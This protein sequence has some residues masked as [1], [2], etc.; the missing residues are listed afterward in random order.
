MPKSIKKEKITYDY[1]YKKKISVWQQKMGY[2][3]SV[4]AP[5]L[6]DFLPDWPEK[7]ALEIGT[8]CGIISLLVLFK[9]KFLSVSGIEIQNS[10]YHLALINAKNNSLS[11]K[12]F[13]LLGDFNLLYK[14]FSG[15]EVIFSNP[16]Y[17]KLAQG[18]I[19][20][21]KQIKIARAEV[22]LNLKDLLE[23]SRNILGL[24]GNLFL[25]LP[26]SRLEELELLSQNIGFNITCIRHIHSFSCGK[27]ERFLVQLSKYKEP[28]KK[29]HPLIIFKE[30][31]IYT[32]EMEKILSG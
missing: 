13:P 12:F 31:G 15:I 28:R 29:M 3:F 9:N 16:P 4:D 8:G 32:E 20:S 1:F 30:K 2:R 14:K 7:K 19:S 17:V 11:H 22:K 23:K 10:L 5:I 18:R 27:P 6:A 25:I 21:N 26:Y 24:N